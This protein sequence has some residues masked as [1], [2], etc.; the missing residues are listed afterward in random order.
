MVVLCTKGLGMIPVL[1]WHGSVVYWG[2][3]NDPC[4]RVAW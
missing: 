2:S 4:A 3:G 1:G